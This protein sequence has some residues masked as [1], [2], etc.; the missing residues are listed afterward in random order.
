MLEKEEWLSAHQLGVV[1]VQ[2]LLNARSALPRAPVSSNKLVALH[3]F[4]IYL[5]ILLMIILLP[6][7]RLMVIYQLRLLHLFLLFLSQEN[8]HCA[9][10]LPLKVVVAIHK[11]ALH[12]AAVRQFIFR[13][14]AKPRV[15]H[16]LHLSLKS[17]VGHIAGYQHTVH[18]AVSKILEGLF[19]HSHIF[20]NTN[21]YVTQ[22]TYH[23]IWRTHFAHGGSKCLE[24]K[25]HCSCKHSSAFQKITSIHKVNSNKFVFRIC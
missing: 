9:I 4:H 2:K 6:V 19:K 10:V 8:V 3:V 22:D 15:G 18:M 23:Q 7:L 11:Q 17:S 1:L 12:M 21:V 5:L 16:K 14:H 13:E 24:V 20:G 25:T